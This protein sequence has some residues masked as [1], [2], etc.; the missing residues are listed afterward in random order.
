MQKIYDDLEKIGLVP[1]IELDDESKAL[2]I[3]KALEDGGIPCAQIIFNAAAEGSIR[4]IKEGAPNV[5]VGAG[6]VFNTEQVDKAVAAG[7]KFIVSSGL[8]PKVVLHCKSRGV[9]I[10]PG[11]ASPSDI[12]TA[13]DL[14]L[15][16]VNFFPAEQAGSLDYVKAISAPYPSIKFMATGGITQNNISK[17]IANEKILACGASWI[18]NSDLINSGDFAKITTLCKEAMLSMFGFS[19]AHLGIN[20]QN[21]DAAIKTANTIGALFGFNVRE[22]PISFFA[23]DGVEIMKQKG[24]GTN[25]HIGIA[26]NSIV[27]SVAFFER[28]GIEFNKDS[29]RLDANGNLTLIYFK[30][31]IAGFAIH[32]VQRK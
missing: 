28:Q 20:A 13:I 7:A 21:A 11:C 2:Q 23:G 14:G 5:I 27:R 32:I 17:Y 30:E 24:Y 6:N 9:P 29:S 26:T 18:A 16:V 4:K 10:I 31:E 19:L 22:T 8:N 3:A 15:N 25:G 12:E 1:I